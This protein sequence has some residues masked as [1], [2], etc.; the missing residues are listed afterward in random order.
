MLNDLILLAGG[1]ALGHFVPML[2][3]SVANWISGEFKD[4]G[5]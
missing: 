1:V 3:T 2:Y 5:L 4:S